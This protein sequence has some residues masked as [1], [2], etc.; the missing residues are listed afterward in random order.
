M[1]KAINGALAGGLV[2][3]LLNS[4]ALWL[5]GAAGVTAIIGVAIKPEFTRPWLYQ[6]LL[7]G[8]IWGLLF[9]LPILRNR[10]FLRGILFSL[11]PSALAF[12]V[13][14]PDAGK[15]VLGLGFGRATPVLVILVNMVWGLA[16]SCWYDASVRSG[17]RNNR[18]S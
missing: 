14:F 18:L 17:R 5:L 11:A 9:L 6:R 4:V 8:G 3:A 13:L 16:A 7:W 15:G 10:V 12:F 2:G 1:L